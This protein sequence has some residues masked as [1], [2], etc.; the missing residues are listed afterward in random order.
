MF[1]K[2]FLLTSRQLIYLIFDLV[3]RLKKDLIELLDSLVHEE[4]MQISYLRSSSENLVHFF[5]NLLVSFHLS[6]RTVLFGV[7]YELE[8]DGFLL[9]VLI[10]RDH[11]ILSRTA[12]SREELFHVLP[13][14]L[15]Y[16][17]V[18]LFAMDFLEVLFDCLSE[19][20]H[21][22]FDESF[23][24]KTNQFVVSLNCRLFFRTSILRFIS[25]RFDPPESWGFKP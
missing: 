14:S 5:N 21:H 10:F 19:P 12:V 17:E 4:S 3:I 20:P 11:V 18:V 1:D 13:K 9:L 2:L 22:K 25:K 24:F 6:F 15:G 16:P 8:Q 23:G 7:D